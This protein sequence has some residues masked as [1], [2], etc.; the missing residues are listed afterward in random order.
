[1]KLVAIIPAAGHG[2]RLAPYPCPKELFPIGFQD[3]VINGT[4]YRRPKV[5]SQ[6]LVENLISAGVEHT[7]FIIGSGKQ[8]L[9][10]Y[11]GDGSRFGT[12]IAY[13]YQEQIN[14]MPGAISLASP[15]I[16]DATVIFGMPDTIIEPRDAFKNILSFHLK[17]EA[18]VTLGL[19]PTDTPSKFGMVDVNSNA[20]VVATVDKPLMTDLKFMWGSACWGREFT[21]IL[22]EYLSIEQ[23]ERQSETVLGDIFNYAILKGLKVKGYIVEDGQFIDIGTS[24]ELDFALKKFHL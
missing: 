20:D 21:N 24:E 10:K 2:S 6:Y 14:G 9:M 19:F 17:S 4:K 16:G 1:M 22:T 3:F 8:D 18:H 15:W 7:F 13:M 12:K 11:Y 5:V 23:T